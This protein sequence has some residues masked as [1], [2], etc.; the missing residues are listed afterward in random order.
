VIPKEVAS[1]THRFRG[2]PP[3]VTADVDR[4]CREFLGRIEEEVRAL[5]EWRERARTGYE[6]VEAG[7]A[8]DI[9]ETAAA[10]RAA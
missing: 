1:M 6:E 7:A 10:N 8:D 5:E 3:N 2:T 4:M 9:D